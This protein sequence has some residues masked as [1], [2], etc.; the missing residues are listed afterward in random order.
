MTLAET[1]EQICGEPVRLTG[2]VDGGDINDAA[3][4][5][6]DSGRRLFVKTNAAPPPGMFAAEAAGLAAMGAAPGGPRIPGVLGTSD[7]GRVL[8]LEWIERGRPG[9]GYWERLGRELAAM[10]AV[11]RDSYGFDGDNYIGSTEQPNPDESSWVVFFR[12]H[13]LGF[14]QDLLRRRGRCPRGLDRALD[15][16]RD[17]LDSLIPQEPSERPALL[18]GDLWGGNAMAGPDGEPVI[19][20]PATYFG[21]PEADLAMTQLF[22]G[23]DHRMLGAYHEHSPLQPGFGERIPLYN[24]YHV[25]N[26]ANLFG[27]G[28]ASQAEA[29]AKRYA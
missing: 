25:L 7:D 1:L 2:R 24:L 6:T 28:Y 16:V 26:H 19:F 11:T 22:G 3:G 12:D 23:F 8:V 4:A 13:R 5:V 21:H 17:R 27:G 15:R 18:H 29:M 10:H 9:R 14:Q 20:D